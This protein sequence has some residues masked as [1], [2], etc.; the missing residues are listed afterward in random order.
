MARYLRPSARSVRV[1]GSK[2]T[3]G[4]LA[5]SSSRP[6]VTT[7]VPPSNVSRMGEKVMEVRRPW[8]REGGDG[9]VA[10][11][12]HIDRDA[13]APK[14]V[15]AH[16]RRGSHLDGPHS[17]NVSLPFNASFIVRPHHPGPVGQFYGVVANER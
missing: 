3:P 11:H 8:L 13:V 9:H 1:R 6:P 2:A 17:P 16:E 7:T 14:E 4:R 10:A 12:D 15:D 5:R